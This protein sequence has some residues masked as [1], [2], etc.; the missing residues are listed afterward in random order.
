MVRVRM[1]GRELRIEDAAVKD[2]LKRGYSV[3]D[4]NGT[5]IK[6]GEV[7]D[8]NQAMAEVKALRL[9]NEQLRTQADSAKK[10]SAR[11]NKAKAEEASAAEET[12]EP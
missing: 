11:A 4:E 5:V 3:V 1:G 8:F 12:Q 7:I 2:Y 9:E 10:K 6:K